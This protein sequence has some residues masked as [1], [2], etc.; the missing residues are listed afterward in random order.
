MPAT[1]KTKPVT[2]RATESAKAKTEDDARVIE[3][4]AQALEAAQEDLGSIG[5]SLGAGA[6]DL[7]KDVQRM[8]RDARRDLKKMS[9]A[10][11]RD[12]ERLQKD[13]TKTT[14]KNG[15]ARAAAPTAGR[16]TRPKGP[17]ASR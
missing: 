7:R 15:H 16:T 4:V 12:L 14:G 17:G 3:R 1:K 11:Q 6:R 9:K 10:L 8:L 5:G 13:L 2:T